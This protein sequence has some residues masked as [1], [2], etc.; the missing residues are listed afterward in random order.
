VQPPRHRPGEP[1]DVG[2]QRRVELGVVG[3]VVA[4]DVHDRRRRPARVVEVGEPVGEARSE[5]QQRRRRALGHAGVAVG[6]AGH[7]ALEQ[8]E[9]RP[10]PVDPIDRRHEV[11]LRRAGIREAHL[12]ATRD[13]RAQE[14]LGPVHLT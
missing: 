12:D 6:H 4:D 10:H 2:R 9:H 5:V 13:E 1:D 7:H 11:H 3:G 8:P 14:A